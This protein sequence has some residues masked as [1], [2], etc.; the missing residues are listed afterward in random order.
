MKEAV[1]GGRRVSKRASILTSGMHA[2]LQGR[3]KKERRRVTIAGGTDALEMMLIRR[4][5]GEEDDAVQ[6]LVRQ[7]T[8]NMPE[9]RA[10]QAENEAQDQQAM[11]LVAEQSVHVVLEPQFTAQSELDDSVASLAEAKTLSF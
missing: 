7:H 6:R 3:M 8:A 1:G 10:R 9:R 5:R 11:A 4:N 2:D